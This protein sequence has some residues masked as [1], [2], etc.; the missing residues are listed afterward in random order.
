M[1]AT[2]PPPAS[3]QRHCDEI[4]NATYR[5]TVPTWAYLN[6]AHGD[7]VS[8]FKA[9]LTKAMASMKAAKKRGTWKPN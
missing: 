3:F 7:L 8:A 4:V 5:D 2:T 6:K 9:A 1:N